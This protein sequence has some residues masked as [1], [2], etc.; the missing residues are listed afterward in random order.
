MRRVQSGFTLVELLIIVAIVG[1]LASVALPTYQDYAIRTKVSEVI[2]ALT[3]C[4]VS[5]SEV[6][7]AGADA[8]PGPNGW[9]CESGAS[10]ETKYVASITTS[11][12]GLAMATVRGV[13]T[14]VNNSVITLTPL[15]SAGTPALFSAGTGQRLFGWRCGSAADGTSVSARYLPSSCRG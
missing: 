10:A 2:L 1:I 12:E 7:Q 4:R 8:A 11:A 9:G 6:Y 3:S 14:A 5:I 13:S 15:A